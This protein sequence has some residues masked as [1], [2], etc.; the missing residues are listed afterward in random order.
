M[1]IHTCE[2]IY[3]EIRQTKKNITSN[4]P[5]TLNPSS[6]VHSRKICI[7]NRSCIHRTEKM[8][9][10]SFQCSIV[11]LSFQQCLSNNV[12][13]F[14]S[15][16]DGLSTLSKIFVKQCFLFRFNIRWF[17]QI[18]NN[19]CQTMLL[20]SFQNKWFGYIIKNVV[21]PEQKTNHC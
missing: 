19:V 2:A 1:N 12:S 5:L 4:R 6:G 3:T 10:V 14:V 7:L 13:C 8:F 16:F 18:I 11:C 15:M 17:C 20:V 21:S 9:L